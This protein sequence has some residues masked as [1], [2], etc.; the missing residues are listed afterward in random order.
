MKKLLAI[1]LSATMLL[2]LTACQSEEEGTDEVVELNS[3]EAVIEAGE[4]VVAISPDFA[5]YE[6]LDVTK[7]GQDAVVGCDAELARYIAS[8]LGVELVIEQMDFSSCQAA[9]STGKVDISISSYAATEERA[10]NMELS[11]GYD[12][13]D[14]DDGHGILILKENSDKYTSPEDFAGLAVAAQS[15]SIQE[16][17]V[18]NQ[19]PTDV[20][21]QAVGSM[22]DAILMLTTN[23][24]EAVV[25]ALT[26]AEEYVKTNDDIMLIPDFEFEFDEEEGTVILGTKGETHLMEEINKILTKADEEGL[27]TKW[28]EEAEAL[29]E[30]LGE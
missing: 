3:Y 15:G 2:S 28:F 18:K 1:A 30:E 27:M 22:G 5:P 24:V 9:V 17:F 8:E 12:W 14:A 13:S 20:A 11:Q 21:Y 10:A 19:M 23:K 25:S 16:G 6:F 26:T 29:A 7:T 4:L